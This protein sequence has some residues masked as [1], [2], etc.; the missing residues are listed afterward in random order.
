MEFVEVDEVK[1]VWFRREYGCVVTMVVDVTA[2][3][4]EVIVVETAVVI[5]KSRSCDKSNM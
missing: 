3:V 1:V 4:V 5:A 2:V